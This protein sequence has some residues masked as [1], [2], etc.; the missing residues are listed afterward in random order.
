MA[1]C[2]RVICHFSISLCLKWKPISLLMRSNLA[3]ETH[4]SGSRGLWGVLNLASSWD[5]DI[6]DRLL[7]I[8]IQPAGRS[9]KIC[10]SFHFFF[11]FIPLFFLFT[12]RF[13]SLSVQ[14]FWLR[15][16][17]G[18]LINSASTVWLSWRKI[19]ILFVVEWHMLSRPKW[20][21]RL[22]KWWW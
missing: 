8:I 14:G 6:K 22:K 5:W 4:Q 13:Q 11:S 12:L 17:Y 20:R 16:K 9:N 1:V 21:K 3:C 19:W 7:I 10:F 2:L 15:A 18:N